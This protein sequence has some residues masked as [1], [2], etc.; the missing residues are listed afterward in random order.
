MRRIALLLFAVLLC[1]GGYDM[2]AEFKIE[3]AEVLLDNEQEYNTGVNPSTAYQDVYG[4]PDSNSERMAQTFKVTNAGILTE[5]TADIRVVGASVS[6]TLKCAIYLDDSG[7]PGELIGESINEC[8]PSQA[9]GGFTFDFEIYLVPG[10]SWFIEF[11][12]TGAHDAT[13]FWRIYDAN[14]NQY[15]D[16]A[17]YQRRSGTWYNLGGDFLIGWT[18][19]EEGSETVTDLTDDVLDIAVKTGKSDVDGKYKEGSAD[20]SLQNKTRKYAPEEDLR[21]YQKI[22]IKALADTAETVDDCEVPD[23]EESTEAT[24]PTQN[25]TEKKEGDYSVDMGKSGTSASYFGY[26]RDLSSQYDGDGKTL[27]VWLYVYDIN[28]LLES[29]SVRIFIGNDSS[30][31]YYKNFSRAELENGWNDIGAALSGFSQYGSPDIN[32]LDWLRIYFYT[33][34]TA[35]T[36][37]HGHL[38]MDYWRLVEQSAEHPLFTGYITRMRPALEFKNGG[39]YLSVNDVFYP[40]KKRKVSIGQQATKKVSQIVEAILAACGLSASEYSVDD[41]DQTIMATVTWDEEEA[42][43]SLDKCVE[44][45]QHHHFV[46]GEGVYQFKSNQWLSSSDPNFSFDLLDLDA[47]KFEYDLKGLKNRIRVKYPTDLWATETDELSIAY[48]GQ[49]DKEV[50]N[51]LMP[52][53]TYAKG[54]AAYMLELLKGAKTGVTFTLKNRYPEILQIQLGSRVELYDP[55]LDESEIYTVLG[56]N[57]KVD[58]KQKHELTVKCKKWVD[59]PPIESWYDLEPFP[60]LS[61]SAYWVGASGGFDSYGEA[62]SFQVPATGDIQSITLKMYRSPQ[63]WVSTYLELYNTDANGLPTGAALATS[64]VVNDWKNH[65]RRNWVYKF[66]GAEQIELTEGA[67]YAWALKFSKIGYIGWTFNGRASDAYGGGVPSWKN[68]SS[69]WTEI[70]GHDRYFKARIKTG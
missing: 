56:M 50:D 2:D 51:E 7:S 57:R 60:F 70:A 29:N 28:E 35:D 61:G 3:Y 32:N 1:C 46:D 12:R 49:L 26:S 52:T 21:L 24:E 11:R 6:D 31:H 65:G 34:S 38:K 8:F 25:G 27:K 42:K 69:V 15:P 37:S 62:Q 20:I 23:W 68:S 55:F 63:Y 5:I 66:S 13:N 10:T 45:G 18:I 44:V 59:I 30:N 9:G 47:Y 64:E 54:V 19:L 33:Y 22:R 16:G 4:S 40:L 17:M 39:L 67:Q 14:S 58:N 53:E 43:G 36:I 48:H 41:T